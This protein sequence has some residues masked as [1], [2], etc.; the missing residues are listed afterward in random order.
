MEN[1]MQTERNFTM[2]EREIAIVLASLNLTAIEIT[3]YAVE[4]KALHEKLLAQAVR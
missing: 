1:T 4:A 2:T 3:A